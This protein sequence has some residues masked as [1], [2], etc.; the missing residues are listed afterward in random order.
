M[1]NFPFRPRFVTS[2]S[3]F[4]PTTGTTYL[5]VFNPFRFFFQLLVHPLCVIGHKAR[6]YVTHDFG[7]IPQLKIKIMAILSVSV[8]N[9]GVAVSAVIIEKCVNRFHP[10]QISSSSHCGTAKLHGP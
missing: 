8:K 4:Y 6:I 10:A 9:D 5:L 3:C 7:H 1:R 2:R